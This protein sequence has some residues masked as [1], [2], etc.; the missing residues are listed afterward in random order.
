[1]TVKFKAK[2]GRLDEDKL[3]EIEESLKVSFP[4]GYRQFLLEHNVAIP[5][6][7][8]I[9]TGSVTTAVHVFFG[10]SDERIYDLVGEFHAFETRIP[11]GTVPIAS[12]PIG[13]LI[14]MQIETGAIYLW[15]HE[16]EA[17]EGETPSYENM[18]MI[19]P[20]FDRFLN[21]IEPFNPEDFPELQEPVIGS[22]TWKAPGFDE[23]F[24]DYLIKK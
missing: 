1:M 21:A 19:A 11:K 24:K 3:A 12:T 9:I 6:N 8:Q 2:E 16:E 13:D 5:E 17:G 14:C 23:K 20:S 15:E 10:R 4:D 22:V 18:E 7:N